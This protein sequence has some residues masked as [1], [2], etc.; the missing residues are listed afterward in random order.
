MNVAKTILVLV[1]VMKISQ[2][3]HNKLNT[4][5]E[6]AVTSYLSSKINKLQAAMAKPD[7]Q[8]LNYLM[9]LASSGKQIN[10][11]NM[12]AQIIDYAQTDPSGETA[13]NSD[14]YW[15]ALKKAFKYDE[16]PTRLR[17]GFDA[18]Q[19]EV[20][21][22]LSTTFIGKLNRF[23][24]ALDKKL[25][26][27]DKI[28]SANKKPKSANRLKS[29]KKMRDSGEIDDEQYN[30]LEK[31]LV[32]QSDSDTTS[33]SAFPMGDIITEGFIDSLKKFVA[34]PQLANKDAR[35][36]ALASTNVK[37]INLFSSRFVNFIQEYLYSRMK[38][39]SIDPTTMGKL[40]YRYNA[41][42]K[43]YKQPRSKDQQ[44]QLE[45]LKK[46]FLKSGILAVKPK[47]EPQ[48]Q[49]QPEQQEQPEQAVPPVKDQQANTVQPKAAKIKKTRDKNVEVAR[50][51][52]TYSTSGRS[53]GGLSESLALEEFVL[54]I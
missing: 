24:D 43:K 44:Q 27:A 38:D 5:D 37:M 18:T 19:K 26:Q 41:L 39:R 17:A 13:L 16:L 30:T 49:Q 47:D 50:P 34:S 36:K 7:T 11:G 12:L 33:E 23:I 45:N 28:I 6:N 52:M 48:A 14:K 31:M 46:V 8:S 25:N 32:G 54:I 29:L 40:L 1:I 2:I 53:R 3:G 10:T 21:Q 22:A 35:K 20:V 15:N 42:R 9:Y 51:W 4:I